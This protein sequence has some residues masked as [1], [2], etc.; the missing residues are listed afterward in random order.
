MQNSALSSEEG[1]EG[2][3]A[4][5]IQYTYVKSR[6]EFIPIKSRVGAVDLISLAQLI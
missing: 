2:V 6:T 1:E 5:W 4:F 3:M